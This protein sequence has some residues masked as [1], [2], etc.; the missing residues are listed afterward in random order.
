MRTKSLPARS[1][2][3]LASTLCVLLAASSVAGHDFPQSRELRAQIERDSVAVLL[4]YTYPASER[5]KM[6]VQRYDLDGDG[7]LGEQER[8]RAARAILPA[9]LAG[10]RMEVAGERPRAG[11]PKLKLRHDAEGEITLLALIEYRLDPL[12]AGQ[13]RR[14]SVRLVREKGEST[15]PLRAS[16]SAADGVEISKASSKIDDGS[17][18]PRDLE[19]GD[20]L[21]LAVT[22]ATDS[23]ES[24]SDEKSTQS[25]P[26]KKQSDDKK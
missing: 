24:A 2:L 4:H 17:V 1:T 25:A 18:G 12:P 9:A 7:E 10:L 26:S 15:Y 6:I 22:R 19:T 8:D 11:T 5:G 3:A 20:T 21:W 23:D 14:F 16:I 13:I